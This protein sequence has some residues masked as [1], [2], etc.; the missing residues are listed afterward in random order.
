MQFTTIDHIAD[1]MQVLILWKK[2]ISTEFTKKESII[3]KS[4]NSPRTNKS[5]LCYAITVIF[6]GDFPIVVAD[7]SILVVIQFHEQFLCL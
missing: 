1:V 6:D 7:K 5:P 4:I 2:T 3:L